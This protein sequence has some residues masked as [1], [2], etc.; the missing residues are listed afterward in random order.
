MPTRNGPGTIAS[1]IFLMALAAAGAVVAHL[2]RENPLPL[3]YTWSDRVALN[4]QAKGMRTV[5]VDEARRIVES[6]SHVVLDARRELDYQAGRLP[7]AMSL[8]TDDFDLHLPMVATLL[9]PDQPILVYCSG[10]ECDESLKLG[11]I[12]IASGYT[13]ITLFAGGMTAWTAAQLPVE[14]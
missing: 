2:V 5:D 3:D 13:N 14:R 4:A 12:L 11:E 7:G 10:L 8:P 1:A 9:T 6:F